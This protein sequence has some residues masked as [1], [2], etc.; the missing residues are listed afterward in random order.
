M[1]VNIEPYWK[2]LANWYWENLGGHEGV[3]MSIWDMIERDYRAQK[4]YHG[5]RGGKLGLKKQM[6]VEFP[7]EQ[8]YTLF[9]LR[10]S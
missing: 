10:W 4:V 3:G 6:I 1:R 8:T 2:K 9:A 5:E 7:D